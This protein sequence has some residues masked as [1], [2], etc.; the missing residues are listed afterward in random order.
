[1][2]F[3]NVILRVLLSH[4]TLEGTRMGGWIP[5]ILWRVQFALKEKPVSRML[6]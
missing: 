3:L 2:H 4:I 6:I 5:V 1:M